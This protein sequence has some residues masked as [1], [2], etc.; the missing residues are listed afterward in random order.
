LRRVEGPKQE[1]A[2]SDRNPPVVIVGAGVAG[3]CCALRLHRASVPFVLLDAAERVGGRVRTDVQDGFTLDHGFQVL[4]T[5]YPE[6]RKVLDLEALRLR[7]FAPGALVRVGEQLHTVADPWRDPIG[8]LASAFAPI[9]TIADKLRVLGSRRAV[10]QGPAEAAFTRLERTTAAHLKESGFSPTIIHRFF[11]PF[12]GGV[13]L[14]PDLSTS[15]RM[16]E[17]TFRMFAEGDAALPAAGIGA[18]PAQLAAQL[19]SSAIVLGQAV[20]RVRPRLV[21]LNNGERIHARHIVLALPDHAAAPL[22]YTDVLQPGPWNGTVSVHY[23][24]P[25]PPY[26]GAWLALDGEG[27]GPVTHLSVQSNVAPEYAPQGT[28]LVCA[29]TSGLPPEAASRG[30]E[31][32]VRR[33]L[34]KIVGPMVESWRHL[35]TDVIPHALP[36]RTPS[37]G[38]IPTAPRDPRLSAALRTAERMRGRD[39]HD[40]EGIYVCGDHW[41][42]PSLNGAML[43]GRLAAEAVLDDRS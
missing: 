20:R 23:A 25:E 40:V 32:A 1:T 29:S 4:L 8:A 18:I 26:A 30:V 42:D 5:A 6:A 3:L 37:D 41:A 33:H 9:G 35:R 11:R 15:S 10:L 2:L 34:R 21:E 39:T 31:A 13:F 14:E 43:S 17:F 19:P 24:A 38:G 22:L 28:A 12:Y 16:F 27:D 7:P 36:R